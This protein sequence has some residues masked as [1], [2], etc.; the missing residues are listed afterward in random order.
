MQKQ[1]N[2][3]AP[4]DPVAEPAHEFPMNIEAFLEIYPDAPPE[5]F[6][7]IDTDMDGKITEE[8]FTAARQSGL[9]PPEVGLG[10]I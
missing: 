6:A 4:L 8:E 2:F 3:D 10:G 5:T 1:G 9:V 7:Q